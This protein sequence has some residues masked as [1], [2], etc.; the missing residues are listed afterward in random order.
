MLRLPVGRSEAGNPDAL[1]AFDQ[2]LGE[3]QR[4]DQCAVKLGVADQR[5]GEMHRRRAIGPDPHRMCGLPFLFTHIEMIVTRRTTPIDAR[6]GLAGNEAAVLP[7]ILAR[8]GAAAAVQTVDDRGRHAPRFQDQARHAG[9]ERP[10]F[11]DRATCRGN[12]LVAALG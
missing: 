3:R 8:P 6:S 11:A 2:N 9:R 12:V 4:D 7:E 10:A 5:G 1:A